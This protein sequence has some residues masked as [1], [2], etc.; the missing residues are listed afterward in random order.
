MPAGATPTRRC[1]GSSGTSSESCTSGRKSPESVARI[2]PNEYMLVIGAYSACSVFFG[3]I[4]RFHMHL[5]FH[6]GLDGEMI[7][8]GCTWAFQQRINAHTFAEPFGPPE[9]ELGEHR[10][11]PS[12]FESLC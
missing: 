2:P 1:H 12:R 4:D 3:R 6:A 8:A 7:R 9:P 5:R 11:F 10:Q